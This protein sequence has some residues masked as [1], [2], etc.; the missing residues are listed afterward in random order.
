MPS[1]GQLADDAQDL[2]D[3]LGV[4]RARH[5]VEQHQPRLHR[6]RPHDRDALLL[7]S[8]KAVRILVALVGKAEAGEELLGLGIRLL[9]R[10]APYFPG[11]QRHVFEHAHVREEVERLEDDPDLAPDAV[12]VD[13]ARRDLLAEDDDPAALD[14]LQEVD[15]AEERRLP[16]ARGADQADD[17]VLG[18]REVDAAQHFVAPEALVDVLEGKRRTV[19]AHAVLP[20]SCLRRSRSISQSVKRASGIVTRMKTTAVAV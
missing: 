1:R 17:L 3:E 13:A 16:R 10:E 4:E 7:T 12:H 15:A 8:R 11:S 5:F 18:E 14:R 19:R 2:G 20:A 6:Q 9:L